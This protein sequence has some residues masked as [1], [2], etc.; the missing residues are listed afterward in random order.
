MKY[1]RIAIFLLVH[2]AHGQNSQSR[3]DSLHHFLETASGKELTLA[4]VQL[5]SL[6]M[7]INLSEA[8]SLIER[9]LQ[10]SEASG[11]TEGAIRSLLVKAAITNYKGNWRGSEQLLNKAIEL[12]DKHS[13]TEGLAYAYTTLGSLNL[14]RGQYAEA[15]DYH[16]KAVAG[17][18]SLGNSDMEVT[19]LLNIGLIKQRVGALDEA[20]KYLTEAVEICEANGLDFRKAQLYINLGVMEFSR[21]NIGSSIDYTKEALTIF[22]RFKDQPNTAQCLQNLG[23]AMASLQKKEEAFAYYNESLAI[24]EAINDQSGIARILLNK[25]RLENDTGNSDG[26]IP[27]AT[28]AW[29]KAK[30]IKDHRFLADA[31][32]FLSEVH[33]SIKNPMVAL[34]YYKSYAAAKDSLQRSMNESKIA[35]LTAEFEFGKKEQ[36]LALSQQALALSDQESEALRSRQLFLLTFIIALIIIITTLIIYHRH[37]QTR[38]RLEQQLLIERTKAAG[39]ER[40]KLKQELNHYAGQLRQKNELIAAFQTQLHQLEPEQKKGL[41]EQHLNQLAVE[42][43]GRSGHSLSWEE[44]RLKFDT[45]HQGFVSEL[46]KQHPDLTPNEIDLCILL[47]VNLSYKDIADILDIGYEAIKKAMQRLFRKLGFASSEELRSYILQV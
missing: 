23:F 40:E 33:E 29:R 28:E 17:A 19:N 8:D 43:E 46:K 45:V 3:I 24:R 30:E 16:F 9:A 42:L 34:R 13:F 14:R 12:S 44:F 47:K 25:A 26:A 7:T 2:Q 39:L 31:A 11:F 32:L 15:L 27:L 20:E 22:R 41:D 35:Q 1:W 18:Q 4:Q 6:I 37:K 21:Q 38:Q 10:S 5:A 36:E